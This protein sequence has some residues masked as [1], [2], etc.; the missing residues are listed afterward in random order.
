MFSIMWCHYKDSDKSPLHC[1]SPQFYDV[2]TR[3]PQA[4]AP[5]MKKEVISPYDEKE[6][7]FALWLKRKW[8]AS[9]GHKCVVYSFILLMTPDLVPTTFGTRLGIRYNW[10]GFLSLPSIG[11][12][13]SVTPPISISPANI[14]PL[15]CPSNANK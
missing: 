6:K 8:F 10:S 4:F 14:A 9:T 1:N 15:N 3:A 11:L 12:K 2:T 13:L 7:W 5:T